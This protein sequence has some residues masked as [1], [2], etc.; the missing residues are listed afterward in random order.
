MLKTGGRRGAS[1]L[2]L[3][4]QHG[5][6]MKDY[7]RLMTYLKGLTPSRLDSELRAMQVNYLIE[8]WLAQALDI[9]LSSVDT[10][11]QQQTC[12]MASQQAIPLACTFY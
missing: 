5:R 11:Q 8:S 12:C 2:S 3:L 7:S 6:M 4:L 9:A 1:E 10:S